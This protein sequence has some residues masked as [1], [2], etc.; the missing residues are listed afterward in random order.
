MKKQ[1]VTLEIVYDDGDGRI[2]QPSEWDWTALLDLAS[3]PET[4]TVVH[5]GPT[6]TV[7]AAA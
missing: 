6:T 1:R 4:V 3:P 5:G 7:K 2:R